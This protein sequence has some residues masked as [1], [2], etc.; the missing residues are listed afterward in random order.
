MK[1]FRN[2]S[3]KNLLFGD[4][5]F[6]WMNQRTYYIH[7]ILDDVSDSKAIKVLEQIREFVEQKWLVH[8][9]DQGNIIGG[10]TVETSDYIKKKREIIKNTIEIVEYSHKLEKG[11]V[12][13]KKE[14][15]NFG[16]QYILQGKATLR[17]FLEMHNSSALSLLKKNKWGLGDIDDLRMIYRHEHRKQ[18]KQYISNT[19]MSIKKK[20][21]NNE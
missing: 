3:G 1:L 12:F 19:V 16:E 15:K 20:E 18:I 21:E 9:D 6:I 8:V 13:D 7:E 10:T 4:I 11:E 2:D 17:E 14:L 5:R